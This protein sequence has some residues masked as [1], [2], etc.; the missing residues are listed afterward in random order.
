MAGKRELDEESKDLSAAMVFLLR[1]I[2]AGVDTSAEAWEKRGYW[3]KADRFR[4]EWEWAIQA[5]EDV[6]DV[7]R[8]GAWD[9]LPRLMADLLP[10]LAGV[11]VKKMTRQPELWKGAHA[12]LMADTRAG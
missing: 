11:Q 3:L 4:L 1:E 5:A 6:E 8:H 9:L 12:L 10:H 2:T 7:I